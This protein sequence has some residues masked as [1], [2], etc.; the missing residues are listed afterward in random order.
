[1]GCLPRVSPHT[2]NLTLNDLSASASASA[3]V[4]ISVSVS[5]AH[6]SHTLTLLVNALSVCLSVSLYVSQ[7]YLLLRP[8]VRQA[9]EAEGAHELARS[10]RDGLF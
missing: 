5:H 9:T 1:M 10:G 8:R 2:L 4:C 7:A 6:H 3:S